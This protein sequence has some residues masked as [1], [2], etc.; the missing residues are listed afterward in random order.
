MLDLKAKREVPRL[1][2]RHHGD[3]R[4]AAKIGD[5]RRQ[6]RESVR[7][8]GRA[9]DQVVCAQGDAARERALQLRVRAR[10]RGVESKNRKTRKQRFHIGLSTRAPR[11]RIGAM[12]A[13]KQFGAGNRT[14]VSVPMLRP[15]R[16]IHFYGL[17]LAANQ[18][19]GV[20]DQSH[21]RVCAGRA[22]RCAL[23]SAFQ[24]IASTGSRCRSPANR[25][26]SSAS[27]SPSG[28]DGGTSRA[29][30]FLPRSMENDMS[31]N[32]TWFRTSEKP[33]A[34]LVAE[35]VLSRMAYILIGLSDFKFTT[36]AL[37]RGATRINTPSPY[38]RV[39]QMPRMAGDPRQCLFFTAFI[40]RKRLFR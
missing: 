3:T 40:H 39:I 38:W 17:L 12:Y 33:R 5:V 32:C 25:R 6:Q 18:D 37:A 22:R 35:M 4:H 7:N 28:T 27:A 13:D 19:I 29:T 10:D 36:E 2:K 34:A 9:D 16:E 1:V 24:R 11:W 20:E 8:R 26:L 15:A 31:R 14:D 30:I 21:L 23:I